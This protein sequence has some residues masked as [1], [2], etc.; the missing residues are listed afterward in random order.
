MRSLRHAVPDEERGKLSE[1]TKASAV[2]AVIGELEDHRGM[3][4]G[5]FAAAFLAVDRR[6][7][8]ALLEGGGAQDEVV[9]MI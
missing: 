6:A 4:A 2:A 1:E 5:A 9:S 3:V 8:H 7:G